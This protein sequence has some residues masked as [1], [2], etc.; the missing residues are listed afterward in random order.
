[1]KWVCVILVVLGLMGGW[2]FDGGGVEVRGIVWVTRMIRGR[3]KEKPTGWHPWAWV[4]LDISH[5]LER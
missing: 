5:M 3:G 2:G 4:R 1:M